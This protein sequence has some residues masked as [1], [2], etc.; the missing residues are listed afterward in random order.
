MRIRIL[1][2][3]AALIDASSRLGATTVEEDCGWLVDVGGELHQQADPS[4]K[5]SNPAPLA[6]APQMAKAA[7]CIREGMVIEA[8][9]ERLLAMGLPLVIRSGAREGVFEVWPRVQFNYHRSGDPRSPHSPR[10][11]PSV[12]VSS[13]SLHLTSQ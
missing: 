4:L 2:A 3:A 5:P 8:G 12:V 13:P 7:Y 10:Q 11:K 1:I 9:D 6:K